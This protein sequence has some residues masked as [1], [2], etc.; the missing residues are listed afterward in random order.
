[1]FY[2]GVYADAKSNSIIWNN[3]E[4]SFQYSFARDSLMFFF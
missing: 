3:V 4:L 1:M 2:D